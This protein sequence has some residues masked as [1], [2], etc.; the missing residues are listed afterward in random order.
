[1]AR[2]SATILMPPAQ[3]LPS[4]VQ[5][6]HWCPGDRHGDL[7]LKWGVGI[8][9]SGRV[10][11]WPGQGTGEKARKTAGVVH[12]AGGNTVHWARLRPLVASVNSDERETVLRAPQLCLPFFPAFLSI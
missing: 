12:S 4:S 7:Q 9:K 8:G 11:E 6:N 5:M 10:T 3:Q 1:M 2:D